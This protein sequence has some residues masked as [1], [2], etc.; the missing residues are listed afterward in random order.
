MISAIILAGGLGTRLR[1]AVPDLPK[2]MA[3]LNGRP[4]LEYQMDYWMAQGI[5]QFVL[6]VGYKH[7]LIEK[8][9]GTAYRGAKIDYSIETTPLG[10]GGGLL[11]AID[12]IR[13][14]GPWLVLNGDTFVEV[15]LAELE[16]LHGANQADITLSLFPVDNNTRYTGVEIDAAQ[17]ITRL[18]SAADG[19]PQLI[20]GGVYLLG[21]AAL[22]GL[23]YRKG[24]KVSFENDILEKALESGKRLFGHPCHGKFIDIGVPEDYARA[25]S[26]LTN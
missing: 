8:H 23:S 17:R 26:L 9:F 19:G 16:K 15:S 1:Q 6:S 25:A 13:S 2:P 24:D 18:R 3:P 5:R 12:R 14:S 21:Q 22:S 7:D 20:N 4:F 11:L 10:T